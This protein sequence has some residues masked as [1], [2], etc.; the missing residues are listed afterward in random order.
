MKK[1]L[2]TLCCASTL[3]A[4]S[5]SKKGGVIS[6]QLD[7]LNV[8][9]LYACIVNDDFTA[10]ARI[11]TIAVEKGKFT[12]HFT[13]SVARIITIMPDR[14]EKPDGQ[15]LG[16]VELLFCPGEH[17]NITG[18]L[19]N[20][21]FSGSKFFTEYNE[22]DGKVK[23]MFEELDTK[24]RK[25]TQQG[26]SQD[27]IS[28][29]YQ[30]DY[31]SVLK[32]VQDVVRNFLKSHPDEAGVYLAAKYMGTEM[33]DFYSGLPEKIKNGPL[34]SFINATTVRAQ[35]DKEAKDA[36]SKIK[37]GNTVPD[38]TL[39]DP[40]GNDVALSSLYN[41]GKYTMLD[42]WGTWC[43]WCIKGIPSM[44]ELYKAN[45]SKLEILSIDCN[46]KA[47]DW[48]NF[49]KNNDVPWIHVADTAQQVVAQYGIQSFPT[50]I[51]LDPKGKIIKVSIGEE[52]DFYKEVTD[53]IK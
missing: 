45:M 50:K 32:N 35:Q 53:I 47:E 38:F 49:I 52:P 48:K 33:L 4:C 12:Y 15:V 11:D 10:L 5:G 7:S 27:S 44:Q 8:K 30:T 51:L 16:A 40:N 3:F 42:F 20:P 37:E 21:A 14:S 34:R 19:A 28:K 26:T 2:L 24:Y 25:L 46:D 41:K 29:A 18:T 1:L 23:N 13:D 43:I 22:I 6:G 17:A 9:Q 39:K 36:A 31:E